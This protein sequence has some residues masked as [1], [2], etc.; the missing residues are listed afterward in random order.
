[1]LSGLLLYDGLVIYKHY[2]D[3]LQLQ[4][5][6]HIVKKDVLELIENGVK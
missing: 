5:D 4:S 3:K 1:M 6:Y 2:I